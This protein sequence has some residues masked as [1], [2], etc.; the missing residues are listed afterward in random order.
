MS[1]NITDTN[2]APPIA[3][4]PSEPAPL[5][6]TRQEMLGLLN[7][8]LEQALPITVVFPNSKCSLESSLIYIDEASH[9][10]LMACPPQW[11]TALQAGAD[12]VRL[13]CVYADAKLEFPGGPCILVD[14]DEAPVVG[15]PIPEFMWRFQRRRDARHTVSGL[16]IVLNLGFLEAEAQVVDLSVSG[17]GLI[18]C[19]SDVKLDDGEVLQ[20]CTIT[21]P[22]VGQIKVD[23][24]IQH[25]RPLAQGDGQSVTRAGCRFSGL[26]DSSRQLIA[27][28]LEAITAN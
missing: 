17:V 2:A 3:S 28:Y 14:L 12:A 7:G 23:L 10:L 21:L 26:S 18:H 15:V 9:M 4:A 20:D 24:V 6:C 19:N 11:Q 25:Q 27:H 13:R 8:I 22:G 5:A 16:S 1:Q